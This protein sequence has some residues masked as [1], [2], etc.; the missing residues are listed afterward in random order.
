M[1]SQFKCFVSHTVLVD[2]FHSFVPSFWRGIG[3]MSIGH[4]GDGVLDLRIQSFPELYYCGFG[5]GVSHFHY[6]LHKF[7]QVIIDRSGL[8]VVTSRLQFINSHN[9]RV[10]LSG[11]TLQTLFPSQSP[12]IPLR[13]PFRLLTSLHTDEFIL[14]ISL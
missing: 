1:V 9:V 5:I 3:R 12:T 6:Q 2:I 10:S 14:K 13:L 7:V 4:C 11:D 8:L